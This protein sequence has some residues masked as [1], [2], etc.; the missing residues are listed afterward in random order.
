[1]QLGSRKNQE[2]KNS[3]LGLKTL[4]QGLQLKWLSE[5]VKGLAADLEVAKIMP[6]QKQYT[7]LSLIPQ[8][9]L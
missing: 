1:M 4:V 5:I 6:T 3:L 9:I 7:K 8:Q 2:C